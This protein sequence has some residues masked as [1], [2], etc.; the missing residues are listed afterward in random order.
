VA[1][2]GALAAAETGADSASASGRVMVNGGLAAAEAGQDGFAAAGVVVGRGVS[3]GV[4]AAA[5]AG[6]DGFRASGRW[7]AVYGR[8]ARQVAA[9]ER[10]REIQAERRRRLGIG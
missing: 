1:I 5:E 2:K 4:M 8:I 10:V 3:T 7:I 6:R 9:L